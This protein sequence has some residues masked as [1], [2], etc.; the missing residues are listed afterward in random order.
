MKSKGKSSALVKRHIVALFVLPFFISYLYFLPPLPYFLA[1]ITVVGTIALWE[2]FAMYKVPGNLSVP[3][4]AIGA[5]LIYLSSRYPEYFLHG[6]AVGM[7]ILLLLRLFF[8]KEPSGSMREIGPLGVGFFYISGLISYQWFLRTEALGLEYIFL[9]YLTVWLSDSMAL[10]IGSS[11]GRHKLCPSIS[12]N[13]TVEGAF[14][15]VIGGVLGAVITKT[16]FDM[17][18][19][20]F[21]SI[22]FIG[23][24]MGIT[25]MVGD[26]IESLFKRDAGIK[27]SS[28]IIPGHGGVLDKIDGM[29]V[30]GPILY[31]IVRY[32]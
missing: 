4:V 14:G 28:T 22:I 20:S 21:V 31:L 15:S 9:L 2:F 18:E 30:S 19:I 27:D 25:A 16:A 5:V 1:L 24:V 29:L 3:G 6:I 23:V 10:Y 7:V 13:K 11:I 17:T 8:M 26:L 12:P 32:L